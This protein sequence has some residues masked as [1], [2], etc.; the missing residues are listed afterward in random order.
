MKKNKKCS[1]CLSFFLYLF[2]S[3]FHLFFLSFIFYL[4]FLF[5][6]LFLSCFLPFF[7]SFFGTGSLGPPRQGG[8]LLSGGPQPRT[9]NRDHPPSGGPFSSTT[10]G[11]GGVDDFG[12]GGVSQTGSAI[13]NR[14][15]PDEFDGIRVASDDLHGHGGGSSSGYPPQPQGAA[16][17]RPQPQGA[18]LGGSEGQLPGH[19]TIGGGGMMGGQRMG[20]ARMIGGGGVGG[21]SK[22]AGGIPQIEITNDGHETLGGTGMPPTGGPMG[23]NGGGRVPP[24]DGEYSYQNGGETHCLFSC[25]S[26]RVLPMSYM[27]DAGASVVPLWCTCSY[28]LYRQ[29]CCYVKAQVAQSLQHSCCFVTIGTIF[30]ER[31]LSSSSSFSFA[32]FTRFL[33]LI[34]QNLYPRAHAHAHDTHTRTHT[35]TRTRTDIQR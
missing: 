18:S 24:I 32:S 28:T 5:Y 31:K 12:V 4:S 30:L 19:G 17:P 16:P 20:D 10:S 23:I 9:P 14:Q 21:G 13:N 8:P 27:L 1:D 35:H 6:F 29:N 34:C 22:G 26:V 3:F 2:L 15:Y 33:N 25:L 7:L 11:I